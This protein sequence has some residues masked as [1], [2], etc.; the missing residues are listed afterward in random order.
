[1]II[2]VIVFSDFGLTYILWYRKSRVP[3]RTRPRS[4]FFFFCY[5]KFI[6]IFSYASPT[7]AMAMA[8]ALPPV[9]QAMEQD[10]G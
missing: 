10:S 2:F 9:W 8:T 5:K 7:M 4:G 3:I 6:N 1:M